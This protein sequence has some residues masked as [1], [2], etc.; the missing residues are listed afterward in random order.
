MY[1]TIFDPAA[2]GFTS[3]IELFKALDEIIK[4]KDKVLYS[5]IEVVSKLSSSVDGNNDNILTT[6]V[7]L[8]I[9]MG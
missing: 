7:R 9:E 4:I 3:F 6:Q 8:N 5:K 2:Y 1:H